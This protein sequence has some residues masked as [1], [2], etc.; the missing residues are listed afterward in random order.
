MSHLTE[1]L[2]CH[3]DSPHHVCKLA[4]S[5][6]ENIPKVLKQICHPV[7]GTGEGESIANGIAGGGITEIRES[8]ERGVGDFIFGKL[9]VI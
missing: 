8:R 5:S 1:L 2:L 9:T 4:A 6:L 3:C 7:V